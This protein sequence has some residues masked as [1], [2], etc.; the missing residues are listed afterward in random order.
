ML[1]ELYPFG[2]TV[3]SERRPADLTRLESLGLL[4]ETRN[5]HWK[6]SDTG[7]LVAAHGRLSH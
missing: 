1:A 3:T 7:R 4:D 2:I 6:A 5:N